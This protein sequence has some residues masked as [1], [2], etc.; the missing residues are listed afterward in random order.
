M[1]NL[2]TEDIYDKAVLA[3]G[4]AIILLIIIAMTI[5]ICV[6]KYRKKKIEEEVMETS[7]NYRFKSGESMYSARDP[8]DAS[9]ASEYVNLIG[10]R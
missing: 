3:I 5:V 4:M 8:N 1:N 6:M 7:K 9:R 2:C 10:N